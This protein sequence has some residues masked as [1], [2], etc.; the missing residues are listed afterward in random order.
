MNLTGTV[1][2]QK[3]VWGNQKAKLPEISIFL[4]TLTVGQAQGGGS[5]A[6]VLLFFCLDLPSGKSPI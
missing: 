2:F 5:A 6:I 4:F 1:N 3:L